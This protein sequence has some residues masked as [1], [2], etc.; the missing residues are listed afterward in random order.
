MASLS[1][2]RTPTQR[3]MKGGVATAAQRSKE[4]ANLA[5]HEVVG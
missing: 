3:P 1:S 5:Q 4:I 2:Q